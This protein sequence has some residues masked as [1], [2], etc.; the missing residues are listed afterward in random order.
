VRLE[1]AGS[2]PSNRVVSR[3]YAK[4]CETCDGDGCGLRH[5]TY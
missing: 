3:L 5:S 1:V 4:K 2:S